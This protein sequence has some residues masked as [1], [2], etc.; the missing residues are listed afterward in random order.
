ML[1]KNK[2]ELK[3]PNHIG[4]IMDG[5]GRWAT[6]KG[7]PRTIGYKHGVEALKRTVEGCLKYDIKVISIFAFSTENW[8]RP[9]EEID[10]IFKLIRNLV[11]TDLQFFLERDIRLVHMGNRDKVP[12]DILKAVD[13]AIEKTKKCKKCILNIGFDYGGRDEIVRAYNKLISDKK[14]NVTEKDVNDALQTA[15]LGDLDILVRT[16]GEQRV[17]NFMLWQMAYSEIYFTKIYWPDFKAKNVDEIIKFYNSRNRRFG[18][19]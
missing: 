13:E 6:K 16:S 15:Y 7:L 14:T 10:E 5:N 2:Q 12:D 11:T 8:G 4:F 1:K 9:Q 3:I 19:I 17:S 18:K